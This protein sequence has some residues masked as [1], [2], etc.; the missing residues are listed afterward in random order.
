MTV[1]DLC[2]IRTVDCEGLFGTW[3]HCTSHKNFVSDINYKFEI[4][5]D[6]LKSCMES[7]ANCVPFIKELTTDILCMQLQAAKL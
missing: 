3:L 1:Q 7:E 4:S 6:K 5:K 2:P